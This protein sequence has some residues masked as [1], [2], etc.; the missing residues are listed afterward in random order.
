MRLAL[1]L[2]AA[3]TVLPLSVADAKDPINV[4]MDRAKVMRISSP[5]E[6]VIVGNPGIADAMIHDR[7]TLII[8]G[9]MVGITNLVILDAKGQPIAD[10]VINVE[11]IQSGLVTVQ[12]G[13]ARASYFCTP[14]CAGMLEVGDSKESFETALAQINQRNNLGAQ[15]SGAAGNSQ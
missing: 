1:A 7:Q 2:A 8:T 15:H 3:A 11:K 10:E 13:P 9:R 12:R 4:V 6:T 5:A 14:H